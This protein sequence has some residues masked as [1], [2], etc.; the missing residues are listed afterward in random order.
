MQKTERYCSRAALQLIESDI[1]ALFLP[2]PSGTSKTEVR[3]PWFVPVSDAPP[4]PGNSLWK[5]VFFV[6]SY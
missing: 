1:P 2:R 6:F 5:S 4:I 3:T